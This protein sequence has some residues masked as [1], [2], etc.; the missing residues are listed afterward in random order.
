L[1][2]VA[3]GRLAVALSQLDTG[4]CPSATTASAARRRGLA[5]TARGPSIALGRPL[6]GA[7]RESRVLLPTG[8][9]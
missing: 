1:G 2:E 7:E 3:E 9:R 8:S 5:M 6:R 4:T